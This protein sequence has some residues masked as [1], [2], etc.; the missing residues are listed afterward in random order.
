MVSPHRKA[1]KSK[2]TPAQPEMTR[3][4]KLWAR[5]RDQR[6]KG[7]ASLER[8]RL[9]TAS[10][11]ETEGLPVPIR[12]A[13]AFEKIVT[14]IPIYIDEGQLMAGDFGSRPMAAEWFPEYYVGWIIKDIETGNIVQNIAE[15]DLATMREICDYWSHRSVRES[16]QRYLD[17][18]KLTRVKEM[19]DEGA[20]VYSYFSELLDDKSWYSPD[21]EK[22]IKKGLSG[23]LADVKE[24][25]EKTRC[26][27]DA[28][29][30][31]RYLLQA[32]ATELQAGIQYGKRYA[33]LARELAQS[34]QGERKRDLERIAQVCDWVPENPARTFH[35]ALQT[36]WFCH[37]LMFF[38]TSG[39]CAIAPGRVDQYLYPYYRRDIDEGRLTREEAIELL[40]CHRVKVSAGRLFINSVSLQGA[41][42]EAYFANCTLGGQTTDGKDATNELSYLWIEAA[43]RTRTPHP[44]LSI[45]YHENLPPDFAMKG[46]ELDRLGLGFPA[47]FG[48]KA[49]IQYWLRKG[50]TLEEARSYT[51]AGCILPVMPHQT[52]ATWPVLMNMPKILELSFWD[53][54]DPV[55][56][57]QFGP[58][59]G[60]F[61]DFK[62]YEELC[63]AYKEQVRFFLTE[64]TNG[65]NEVRLFRAAMVPQ[66]FA[67]GLFD[68]C[69]T[70]GQSPVSGGS[71]YQ[72]GTQYVLPIG[73]IDV[74]DSLAAIK[75][76]VYQEGSI[77][78][79][80]LLDAISVNF[81]GKEDMRRLLLS[82]PK[83]GNGLEYVDAIAA[84]LYDWFSDMLDEMDSCFGAKYVNA[85]HSLSFQ[86][87]TGLH[88]GALPSGRLATLALADGGVSPCQGMDQ[89]GPTAV[90]RSAARINQVPIY[91]T[92]FNMKFHPS[93]LKTKEDLTKFLALIKTYLVDYGGEHIQFNVIDRKTLLDAQKH[94]DQY[95]NLVVRVAGYSALWVEL[96]SSIQ[97]EIIKRSEHQL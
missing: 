70:R 40:E 72:Q 35:E 85:P 83:Y 32:L 62:T 96:S 67:S 68:D 33:A 36:M 39:S 49:Y 88:V 55:T 11:K 53:G 54:L 5:L 38:D 56:G 63:K 50:L 57:K 29:R 28:S 1:V 76:H 66:V 2:V 81:E 52:G 60:R 74:A 65:L 64:S 77:G 90:I 73:I 61:E 24:E 6:D 12:R 48:D 23:I 71:R 44:T 94:P 34:A 8:A 25:L 20:W 10:F 16:I 37:L 97:N 31:K 78:K 95:R 9:L 21:F 47:W 42:G 18:E 89:S 22:A 87:W 45:R 3:G 15:D 26:L 14:G 82:A 86:G 91:G 17:E 30:D 41:S 51:L 92:L 84:D 13:K 27:D 7:F 19:C 93:A 59:T 58:K 75:K 69:I 80:T 4:Q 79:Q 43:M 46:A